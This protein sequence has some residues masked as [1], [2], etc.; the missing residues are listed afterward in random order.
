MKRYDL[1][2]VTPTF[3]REEV[4]VDSI[5]SSLEFIGSRFEGEIIVVDDCSQDETYNRMRELFANELD[6][7]KIKYFRLDR[8]LGVTGAKNFGVAQASG[9]WIVFMDSDDTF[10]IDNAKTVTDLI[11]SAL[12][13]EVLF[14]RCVSASTKSLLGKEGLKSARLGLRG[15]L[16]RSVWGE[17]LPVIR[18][19]VALRFPYDADLRGSEGVAYVRMANAG[20]VFEVFPVVARIYNDTGSDRLTATTLLF[21]NP[22]LRMLAHFRVLSELKVKIGFLDGSKTVSRIV[23]WAFRSFLNTLSHILTK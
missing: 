20:I 16:R 14:F 1:S 15:I 22:E 8:N 18:R 6:E 13:A 19:S 21:A 10:K 2:I 23:V 7:G 5:N 4:L 11:D 3:N 12:E 9:E 17:C